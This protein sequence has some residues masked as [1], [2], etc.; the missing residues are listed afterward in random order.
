MAFEILDMYN[1]KSRIETPFKI[2]VDGQEFQGTFV[3]EQDYGGT[4]EK[5]IEWDDNDPY[6]SP[7]EELELI[8]SLEV[9]M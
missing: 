8:I 6:L 5:Y 2:D 4:E 1:S 9:E 3:E 7:S